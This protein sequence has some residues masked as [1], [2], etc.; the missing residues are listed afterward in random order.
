MTQNSLTAAAGFEPET[1]TD[2]GRFDEVLTELDQGGR[3]SV[4]ESAAVRL[5]Y[6]LL[7][8]C[9]LSRVQS[10]R[11]TRRATPNPHRSA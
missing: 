10:S 9:T 3:A 8:L 11:K 1:T 2:R 5:S 6:M 4:T 7:R